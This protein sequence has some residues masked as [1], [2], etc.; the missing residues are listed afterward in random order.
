MLVFFM[1]WRPTRSTQSRSSAASEVDKRQPESRGYLE[2]KSDD[3]LADP[4]IIPNYLSTEL[5]Q[6]T[7]VAGVKMLRDIYQQPAFKSLYDKEVV[8]G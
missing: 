4:R 1:V 6:K 5:D 2:I 3:P 8:P 7:L